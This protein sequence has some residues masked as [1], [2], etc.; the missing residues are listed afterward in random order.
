MKHGDSIFDYLDLLHYICH[1][2]NKKVTIN[3]KN[4]Y[5][6][7]FQYSVTVALNNKKINH[8]KYQK[9]KPLIDIYDQKD[10]NYP[11]EKDDWKKF[12]KKNPKNAFIV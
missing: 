7:C 12:E 3:P 4:N 5:G 8:K 11:S 6:K 9:V 2:K 1:I 10:I